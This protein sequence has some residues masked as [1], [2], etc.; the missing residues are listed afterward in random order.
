MRA[1]ASSACVLAALVFATPASAGFSSWS[2]GKAPEPRSPVFVGSPSLP[3]VGWEAS[4]ARERIRDARQAGTISR[5]QAR[6]LRREADVLD[7]H[8]ELYGRDGLSDS[9]RRELDTRALYLIGSVRS[10]AAPTK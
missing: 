8:A 2:Y 1:L 6:E 10:P 7:R 5:A 4:D 9:E 3:T